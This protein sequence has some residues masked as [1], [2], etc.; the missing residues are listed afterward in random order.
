MAEIGFRI[1]ESFNLDHIEETDTHFLGYDPEGNLIARCRKEC[2]MK[3]KLD[4]N[5]D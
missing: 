2:L 1:Y 3:L 4:T 5:N